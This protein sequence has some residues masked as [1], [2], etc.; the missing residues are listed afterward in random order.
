MKSLARLAAADAAEVEVHE[1]P[2]AHGGSRLVSNFARAHILVSLFDGDPQKW[3][4]FILRD[5]TAE[6]R[7]NDVPFIEE[8]RARAAADPEYIGRLRDAVHAVSALLD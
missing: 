6:E 1:W 5:G 2:S 7:A 4:D 3:L 8:I